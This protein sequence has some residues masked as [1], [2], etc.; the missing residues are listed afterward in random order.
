MVKDSE[1]FRLTD[2]VEAL[3]P[4][5]QRLRAVLGDTAWGLKYLVHNF[6][7]LD[8]IPADMGERIR[9]AQVVARRAL[10]EPAP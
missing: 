8:G 10:K 3:Q 4:Q 6:V 5:N 1:W 9:E 2:Q 7:N